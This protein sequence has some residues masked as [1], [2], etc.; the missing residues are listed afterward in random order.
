VVIIWS[1][2]IQAEVIGLAK[3]VKRGYKCHCFENVALPC[4][5]L[6]GGICSVNA[7]KCDVMEVH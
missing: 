2:L 3:H 1:V 5:W 7:R 6:V 4:N